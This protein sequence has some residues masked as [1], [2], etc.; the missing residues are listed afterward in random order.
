MSVAALML[1]RYYAAA[2]GFLALG[3]GALAIVWDS[4]SARAGHHMELTALVEPVA[5]SSRETFLL[6]TH[7]PLLLAGLALLA[8]RRSASAGRGRPR[9]SATG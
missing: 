5:L 7:L 8:L 3:A 1:R 2:V 4:W 9:R 6:A